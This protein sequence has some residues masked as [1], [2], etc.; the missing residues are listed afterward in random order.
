MA[1]RE[2]LEHIGNRL[3]RWRSYLPLFLIG[4]FLLGLQ[5]FGYPRHSHVLDRTWELFCLAI[6][7]L[8]LAIRMYA[9]GCA[10]RGT[11]GRNVTEQRASSL[12][13]TGMYSLVRHPL[14]L[15]NFFIWFGISLSTRS[16]WL[17]SMGVLIFWLYYERIIFAEEE[18]LRRE[19]GD[20]FLNWAKDTPAFLPTKLSK[21]RP[22]ELP[23]KMRNALRREYSGF[24]GIIAVYSLLDLVEETM[25][26]GQLRMDTLWTWFF[27]IGL[28]IYTVLMTLKKKT[29]ILD[30]EGR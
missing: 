23:F 24:F 10:P 5:N 14:Y 9:V 15:G 8:G 27:I 18:F 13:T 25:T 22:A 29:H 7:F 16:W 17:A 20:V 2:E 6:S 12:N 11:S 1:L 3:F 28:I 19:F 4:L 30:V 21:W 26:E